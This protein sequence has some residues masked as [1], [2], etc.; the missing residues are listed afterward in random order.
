MPAGPRAALAALHL[1]AP[2]ADLLA[3]LSERDARDALQY[4]DRS[5]ISLALRSRAPAFLSDELAARAE[6]NLARLRL[7]ESTYEYLDRVF[8]GLEWVALKG[9]THCPLSRMEPGERV[10]YDID[11][12]LPRNSAEDAARR[13]IADG[14]EHAEGMESFPTDHLPALARRMPFT[15]CG[16]FFASDLP[17]AIELHYRFWN[18]GLER[19]SAS[20]TED[21]WV[22][23]TKRRVG[24]I[25]LPVLHAP[26]AI[27][28]AALHLL[29][30]MLQGDVKPAHVYE[31]AR[32]LHASANDKEL[33]TEWES[34]HTPDLRRL[35]A[36]T[37]QLARSWFGGECA[38]QVQA[39]IE[40]LPELVHTWFAEFAASPAASK[41]VPN[42]D[43]LWLHLALL[44]SFEDRLSVAAR[45]IVPQNLP[46][47]V[48]AAR[49]RGIAFE[50]LYWARYTL[51][52]LRYHTVSLF[53]TAAS[54]ARWWWRT[55]SFGTQFWTFL[56]AAVLFNFALFNFFLLYNLFLTD[57]G[58][59]M[60][61]LGDMNGAARLG[62]LAGTLPAAWLAHRI[63]LRWSLVGAIAGTALLT[64]ARALV[65]ANIPVI[66]LAF[67]ASAV[68]S[69]WAVIM[70]P[71]IAAAVGEK[72]RAAAF[73]L[74]FS[75]MFATGILGNWIAGQLPTLLHGKQPA[76]IASAVL[77]ATALIPA[78]R[79]KSGEAPAPG[80]RIYPRSEFLWRYL[81]AFAVWHLA[82][83]V[84]NPFNNVYFSELKFSVA[85]IG[86]IFSV[87]QLVQVFA[88]LLAPLVIKRAGLVNGI[89]WM[90]RATGLTLAGLSAERAGAQ[91][92][93]AYVAYMA[94]QWMSEPGLNTLLMNH[95]EERERSGASAMNYLVAFSAQAVAAFAAGAL[96]GEYGFGPVLLGA[97]GL[98]GVAA[99]MFRGI[100][101]ENGP[102]MNADSRR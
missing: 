82:T 65:V 6:K 2:R 35:E 41:F 42:K 78:L 14:Y 44:E 22:R 76:L 102:Q 21:F 97:A 13:L 81:G 101:Q 61:A 10:Q 57:H 29:K 74:F 62:S 92:V 70:A 59:K 86:K 98:A 49:S 79:L 34:L 51:K 38:P 73:S 43:E 1:T 84:F 64:L 99:W 20:D 90:M 30:H 80:A 47:P 46:P 25:E 88:V 85:A 19:L 31:L 48:A 33:W 83:G 60:Q 11:L 56:L 18:P 45:R 54:G 8:A 95:V 89:V 3:Q 53:T 91:A 39:E 5:G 15:W 26:D 75:T 32:M 50:R 17:L 23:R 93:L 69:V 68:F 72:R 4:C 52:R 58:Y 36:V 37:F 7:I 71:S 67:V 100:R 94:C 9:I 12:Y 87:S 63:G 16:D 28:Y 66:A 55:N 96:F 24:A 27:A 40:R 77:C